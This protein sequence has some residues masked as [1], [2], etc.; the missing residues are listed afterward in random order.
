[1][2]SEKL[3]LKN[4][5]LIIAEKPS[6]AKKIA[7]ALSTSKIIKNS[8]NG[9]THY[10][11]DNNGKDIIVANAVGHL[12]GLKQVSGTRSDYP[13]FDIDWAASS[14]VNKNSTFTKKYLSE[15]KKLAKNANEF[16]I[17]TDYDVEGE[18][19]GLNIIR[20]ACKQ[21]DANRMKFSTTTKADLQEAY[22]N[23]K[24]TLDWG[25]AFAGE[26]R[27]K[28]D[29]FYGINISR[30]LTQAISEQGRYKVMSTGRV[31]G[32]S[33]KILT[34]KEK[35]IQE[36]KSVPY[37]ELNIT[38]IK[39]SKELIAKHIKDKF[40]DKLEFEN[41]KNKLESEKKTI[42]DE[43]TKK[44]LQQKAPNPFDLTSLQI[45]AFRCFRINPKETL[46]IAQELYTNSYIS[47]P[48]TSSNQLPENIGFKKI[49]NSLL[50]ISD[51]QEI[52]TSLLTSTKKLIPNNG[53]KK[54]SA[55][56]AVYPTGEIPKDLNPRVQKIYDLIVKRFIATFGSSA[57]RSTV[58]VVLNVKEEK[59]ILKGILT[60]VRGWYDLYEPYVNVKEE[61]LP[62]F[63]KGETLDIKK[64]I[65]EEKET[66]PPKRYTPASIIK[67]LEK[68]NLGTKATRAGI[69]DTLSQ[70]GYIEG[71]PIRVTEVGIKT[72]SVLEN[73]S[74]EILDEELTRNFEL[75]MEEIRTEKKKE[76]DVL[77][78]AK[79]VITKTISHF[80]KRKVGVGEGLV[81]AADAQRDAE[82][83]FGL[84]P[85]CKTGRLRLKT[86]KFGQFLSCDKY[87]D[88]KQTYNLPNNAL[89][90]YSGNSCEQC[91]A[92]IVQIIQKRLRPKEMCINPD[93]PSRS[94]EVEALKPDEGK[95]CPQCGKGK[96]VIK[97]GPYGVFL[98]CDKYP[99][100]KYIHNSKSKFPKKK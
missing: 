56:P 8:K 66:Q 19:I 63:E 80:D 96:L 40:F 83:D 43:I 70:R 75:E 92:P 100:C 84:C 11:I 32:P 74:P 25:Q 64:L 47:Y 49:L 16:T 1:M 22:K 13:V 20:Y 2:T 6:A 31:Q 12:Y 59:F 7:E 30:A 62:E 77:N 55:H 76:D 91:S 17:A 98:A 29:W 95:S 58:K 42:V 26:T 3:Q 24:K 46:E 33:L 10:I 99:T 94:H 82:T 90:K 39:E 53:T 51:Y 14:E 60:K 44:D 48:R 68:K 38:I 71:N 79:I 34:D 35:S 52:I 97:K 45:E 21:K 85:K 50:R 4:Y 72:E 9:V 57:T 67:E 78:E 93:C 5:E 27:H 15:L 61:E 28:L 41:I 36:F 81:E 73:L 18:V 37:W 54:D 69:I 23:K 86:G 88:C 89:I 87:P 65:D